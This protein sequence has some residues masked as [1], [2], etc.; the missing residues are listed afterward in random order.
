MKKNKI[1]LVCALALGLP[2]AV[3]SLMHN[4]E[5]IVARAETLTK[6]INFGTNNEVNFNEASLSKTIDNVTWNFTATGTKSLTPQPS[7]N[8][9][10]S[11]S[12]PATSI[13]ITSEY[14]QNMTLS[15]FEI[16]FGGFKGT[17][18]NI[19]C[20]YAGGSIVTGKLNGN[21]DILLSNKEVSIIEND[22][23]K[24]FDIS[25]SNISKGVKLYY[26][27][28]TFVE[29][30][31]PDVKKFKVIYDY[32]YE[33]SK[34][35]STIFTEGDDGLTLPEP[36]R[37]GYNFKGW[38]TNKEGTGEKIESPYIPTDN[39]TLYAKWEEKT[40]Y[41]I[42]FMMNDGT[43]TVYEKLNVIENEV[44]V[45][46]TE[47]PTRNG[48]RFT[49]WY[50]D[51]NTNTEYNFDLK[52]NQNITLYAGW[53]ECI[54][55]QDTLVATDLSATST[56]YKNFSNVKKDNATYAGKN[57][58]SNSGAI[59]L[60]N[61]N[62]DEGIVSTTSGGFIRKV[63]ISW[64]ESTA[65][66]RRIDVYGS[67]NA[68]SLASDLYSD[69]TSGK[70]LSSNGIVKGTSTELI[71]NNDYKYVGIRSNYGALYINS[72]TFE[73]EPVK[74]TVDETILKSSFTFT[75]M[76]DGENISNG[77]R[78]VGS[79]KEDK[80][81]N[82][83]NVGFNFTLAS[84]DKNVTKDY[85]VE[86]TKLYNKIDDSNKLVFENKE[87]ET[88]TLDGYLSYSLIL[89][90][91]NETFNAT[92]TFYSYAIIDGVTYNSETTSIKIVNGAKA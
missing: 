51:S 65:N 1:L 30:T 66:G 78:F 89:N 50:T 13:N 46:P 45:S 38:F 91:I 76:T 41:T 23:S 28:Y 4:V 44:S 15:S 35:D 29:N 17:A 40:K 72:I 53:V 60:N 84:T 88:F 73:W 19:A 57:S 10:G 59:Q 68:Y 80:F 5:P 54:T 70:L 56:I 47:S 21:N 20:N 71:I 24:G 11:S 77:I 81:A 48:F 26:I 64:D 62:S 36:T 37:Y 3:S 8:Q 87:D 63:I 9:I 16:K 83:S 52:I 67:N 12:K 25:I 74:P 34:N 6:T 43:D 42:T 75:K 86:T 79:V 7:Y 92:I 2:S 22:V 14:Y 82:L 85:A 27:S 49:G 18:G 32:N 58:K 39:V 33:N 55:K 69:K 61:K 31:N 90:N